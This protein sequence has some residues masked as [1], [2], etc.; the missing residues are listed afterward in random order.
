MPNVEY[1]Y[2]RLRRELVM[3]YG[4]GPVSAPANKA[5][6]LILL[7]RSFKRV[8]DG[9]SF[10]EELEIL[11]KPF[12]NMSKPEVKR[13]LNDLQNDFRRNR[14]LEI[15]VENPDNV[16]I[17]NPLHVTPESKIAAVESLGVTSSGAMDKAL[18]VQPPKTKTKTGSRNRD[19]EFE[20]C[21]LSKGA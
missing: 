2:L 11:A 8:P 4:N 3:K 13:Q 5:L 15:I 16:S 6:A 14:F 20:N 10:Q 12:E 9:V 21:H 7:T 18:R 19:S 1:E 17:H